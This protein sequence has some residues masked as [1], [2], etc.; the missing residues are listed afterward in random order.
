MPPLPADDLLI[1]S[2]CILLQ[3][4]DESLIDELN[5]MCLIYMKAKNLY[6]LKID[7]DEFGSIVD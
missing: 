6:E 3:Y 7:F 4:L 5:Q 2:A 1:I